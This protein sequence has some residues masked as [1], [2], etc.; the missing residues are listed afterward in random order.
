MGTLYKE[1]VQYRRQRLS[2]IIFGIILIVAV[3][4]MLL[5][6][7]DFSYLQGSGEY[8]CYSVIT[9]A[10]GIM[11]YMWYRGR[12]KYKYL[13]IDNELI[14]EKIQGHKRTVA[15]NL[16]ARKILKLE[17]V[18]G[19]SKVTNVEQEYHF[20]CSGKND[21][22]YRCIFIKNEKCYSFYFEP[23]LELLKR[24]DVIRDNKGVA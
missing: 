18:R 16:N 14:I 19:K 13:I 17:K 9:I 20:L 6:L 3:L 5:L 12:V 8:A 1:I 15:I 24:L 4:D 21:N 22:I 11:A 10:I 7:G 2:K 23:S